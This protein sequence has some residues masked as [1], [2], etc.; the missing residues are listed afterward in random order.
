M[1][2]ERR[3][4]YELEK[5]PNRSSF[6]CFSPCSPALLCFKPRPF[7]VS[8]EDYDINKKIE[9][10]IAQA[11]KSHRKEIKLLLLG[12][13]ESGKST[14]VKQMKII[15]GDVF[16]EKLLEEYKQTIYSNILRGMKV[17]V[18][19]REKLFIPWAD[20][21]NSVY[22]EH[23]LSHKNDSQSNLTPKEFSLF[24]SSVYALWSDDGIKT[25]FDRRNE[26]CLSDG[27]HYLFNNL[28]RI[29]SANYVPTNDDILHARKATKSISEYS[30][31]I[32]NIPFKFVDVG[33]QRTQRQKWIRCFDSVTSILFFV[34]SSEY[35]QVL[36]EDKRTNR[37]IESL[38]IFN[39]IVN[40]RI[41]SD[42]SMILFLNK[43]DILKDKINRS[44][45]HLTNEFNCVLGKDVSSSSGGLTSDSSPVSSASGGED[46]GLGDGGD[47]KDP[48]QAACVPLE[49]TTA[50]D[51]E[52]FRGLNICHYLPEYKGNP[53]DVVQVQKYLIHLFTSV[54]RRPNKCIFAH[55]TT[56]VDTENIK[57]VFED[58]KST[59]LQRNIKAL[60]L[61]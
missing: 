42:V 50:E 32:H 29:S 37:L 55:C 1:M 21:G 47:E 26:F 52:R 40:N 54:R 19:A 34:A 28:T 7:D 31:L 60:M 38:D 23:L 2:G 57:F 53:Y 16:D 36:V 33:G 3:K 44:N 20:E 14:F 15:H 46:D 41:F 12:A 39:F 8:Q 17:L 30:V 35:D 61:E 43:C 10:E 9:R 24:A 6:N 25:A 4:K 58:V 22:A 56:A 59:I 18:D 13:G 11:K 45:P 51:W 5:S 27:I 48:S 49:M